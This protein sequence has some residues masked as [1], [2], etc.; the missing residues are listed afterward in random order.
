MLPILLEERKALKGRE[1]Q[2][3]RR[4]REVEVRVTCGMCRVLSDHLKRL[5]LMSGMECYRSLSY[6]SFLHFIHLHRLR[7]GVLPRVLCFS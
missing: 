3:I 5:I 4:N 1:S 7:P 6:I 2:V